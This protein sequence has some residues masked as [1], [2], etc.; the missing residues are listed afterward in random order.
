M[1]SESTSW[2][3]FKHL[4]KRCAESEYWVE[5][6][7]CRRRTTQ[8]TEA[9]L[10]VQLVRLASMQAEKQGGREMRRLPGTRELLMFPTNVGNYWK[11]S[12]KVAHH[13][14]IFAV[15]YAHVF[16]YE[17]IFG[18]T[19]T[20]QFKSGTSP[21][22]WFGVGGTSDKIL[23]ISS[24]QIL[25]CVASPEFGLGRETFSKNLLNKDFWKTNFWKIYIKFA[26]KFKKFSKIFQE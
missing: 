21:G 17:I 5:L 19:I 18:V 9:E 6:C 7:W 20:G 14:Y 22:F 13:F 10:R 3:L 2:T 26:Q 4:T 1:R 23:D 15:L 24:T 16:K 12:K 8:R 25:Y 11:Y